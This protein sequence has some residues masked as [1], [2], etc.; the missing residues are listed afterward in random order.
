MRDLDET[1]IT[2]A[3]LAANR[4][5]PDARLC[6]VMTSLV[7]HLHAFARD[8]Q[9]TEAEW[10]QGIALLGQAAPADDELALLS[11]VL[12]L[13]T[14]VLAQHERK[15][16]ACTPATAFFTGPGP[17]A[18]LHDLGADITP[19]LGGPKGYVQGVVRDHGGAAVPNARLHLQVAGVEALLQADG[20]GRYHFSTSLP[21]SQPVRQDGPVHQLLAVLN[22]TAWRPAH[23]ALGVSAADCQALAT[24]LYR[25]GDPYLATDPLFAVRPAL[26]IPWHCQPPGPTPDGGHSDEVFYT[27]AFDVVLARLA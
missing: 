14:L 22:R 4:G 23:L 5:T 10:R 2:Q 20:H 19:H 17:N 27:L 26:T 13:S 7:Q 6:A 3:V 8:I 11:S 1:T 24:H 12:G 16:A 21:G 25:E 18:V 9:L 15:P